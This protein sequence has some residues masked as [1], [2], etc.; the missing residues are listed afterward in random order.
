MGIYWLVLQDA[1]R[2]VQ[3]HTGE[4]G[5]LVVAQ[6]TH[7]DGCLSSPRLVRLVQQAMRNPVLQSHSNGIPR[8]RT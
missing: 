6:S 1:L 8:N 2:V 4:A 3:S 7:K 5:N